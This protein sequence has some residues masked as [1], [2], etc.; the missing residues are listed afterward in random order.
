MIRT[1]QPQIID[2][3]NRIEAVAYMEVDNRREPDGVVIFD[4]LIKVLDV[5]IRPT[6]VNV[7]VGQN[8]QGGDIFTQEERMFAY[9]YFKTLLVRES[10]YKKSTFYG[11]VGNPT[12]SEYDDVMIAQINYVNSRTWTG[13]ELQKIYYWNLTTSDMEKVTE[14]ELEQLLTPYEVTE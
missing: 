6:M 10:K 11:A 7:L 8:E 9:P 5:E 12:P 1:T 4:T 14:E 2:A 3:L 13:N